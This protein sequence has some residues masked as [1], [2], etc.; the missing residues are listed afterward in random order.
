MRSLTKGLVVGAGAVAGWIAWGAY[1]SRSV[2]SIPYTHLRTQDG[3]E[4]RRY[5]RAVRVETTA[6]DQITAFRRLFEYISGANAG[7]ESISMT[8]PVET[9]QGQAISMTAPVRSEAT[10][11]AATPGS[12]GTDGMR[13]SFSLPPEYDAETAPDPTDPAVTLLVDP[14][15]TVAV[16]RFSWYAP[17]WRVAGLERDL[18]RT[19]EGNGVEPVGEPYLLRYDDPWTPPFMRRNEVAAE[20]DA[21]A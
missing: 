13:M 1:A 2:E 19:I 20:I 7:D 21:N 9:R 17:Q 8:A 16:K 5:P 10:G 18:L 14:P 15:K 3:V 6:P 12:D 4:F 11:R